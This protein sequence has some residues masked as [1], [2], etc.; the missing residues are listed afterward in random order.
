MKIDYQLF[1]K[2]EKIELNNLRNCISKFVRYQYSKV[3]F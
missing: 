2:L 1:L 3:N